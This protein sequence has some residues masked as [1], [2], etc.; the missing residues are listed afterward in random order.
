MKIRSNE[1]LEQLQADVREL[2][3]KTGYLKV[4]ETR[5]L[6]TQPSGGRWSVTQVLEHLNSY[7]RYYLPAIEKSVTQC[8]RPR[9]EWFKPGVLGDYFTRIMRPGVNGKIANKMQAPKAHRPLP[10]FDTES[11]IGAFVDQQFTLLNLLEDAK[12]K[13]IGAIRTPISISRFIKI[14]TGDTFRFLIAHQQRHFI[15]IENTLSQLRE[16]DAAQ[17]LVGS[18]VPEA[19]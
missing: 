8:T 15:Q 5:L 7:G 10:V 18:L 3:R 19:M 11:V 13:N 16:M 6:I 1:L 12:Q 2:I 17:R 14:K 9:V 4:S